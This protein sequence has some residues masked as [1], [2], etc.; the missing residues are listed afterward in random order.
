MD[1]LLEVV[2]DTAEAIPLRNE[3]KELGAKIEDAKKQLTG[4]YVINTILRQFLV[5]I[6]SLGPMIFVKRMPISSSLV[7]T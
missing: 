1:A 5:L 4:K 2:S 3:I 7:K 6:S